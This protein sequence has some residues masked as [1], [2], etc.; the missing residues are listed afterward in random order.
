GGD[1]SGQSEHGDDVIVEKKCVLFD[2]D[3]RPIGGKYAEF[4]TSLGEISRAHA[5]IVFQTWKAESIKEIAANDPSSTLLD[6]DPNHVAHVYGRDS[7]CRV[8]A[9]MGEVENL[10]LLYQKMQEDVNIWAR[11]A[12]FSPA[13]GSSHKSLA[14]MGMKAKPPRRFF[15]GD[16]RPL[17]QDTHGNVLDQVSFLSIIVS[18]LY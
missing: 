11:V 8:R 7:K 14:I 4:S 13:P 16:Y 6:L 2:E 12:H 10:K 5:S 15:L 1:G 17:I 9:L 3:G 18:E